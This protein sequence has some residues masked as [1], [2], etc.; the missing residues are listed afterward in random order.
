MHTDTVL[1]PVPALSPLTF[2]AALQNTTAPAT[3]FEARLS[4]ITIKTCHN[5][6]QYHEIE[7]VTKKG[8]YCV[9]EIGLD[10]TDSSTEDDSYSDAFGLVKLPKYLL[11]ER[12]SV[13][14]VYSCRLKKYVTPSPRLKKH[15]ENEIY[16]SKQAME[17]ITEQAE[18]DASEY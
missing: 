14:S 1:P 16:N 10:I 3:T 7:F 11:V 18:S 15:L 6:D 8:F 12:I 2:T 4:P 13:E 9:L 5:D 17:K